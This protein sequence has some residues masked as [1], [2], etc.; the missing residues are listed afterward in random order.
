M[1]GVLVVLFLFFT[2]NLTI[3]RGMKLTPDSFIG[4]K[5]TYA[6]VDLSI[7]PTVVLY[8]SSRCSH[9]QESAPFYKQLSNEPV[10]IIVVTSD[11]KDVM[12]AYV[13]KSGYRVDA[14]LK[15]RPKEVGLLPTLLIVDTDGKIVHA[16]IGKLNENRQHEVL[17]RIHQLCPTCQV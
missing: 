4:K 2:T 8:G 5:I 7:K 11:P 10:Q 12:K 6:G 3:S 13:E 9:C 15:N 17:D 16:A 1:M 14:I